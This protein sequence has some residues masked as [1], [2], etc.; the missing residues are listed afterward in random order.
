MNYDAKTLVPLLQRS[1]LQ[2]TFT[3]KDGTARVMNCTLQS[4]IV[5]S[6]DVNEEKALKKKNDAV[7]PVWDI[8]AQAWRS[9]RYDAITHIEVNDNG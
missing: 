5:P 6:S 4:S 9:F 3:K 8:D 2:V 7:C 1:G